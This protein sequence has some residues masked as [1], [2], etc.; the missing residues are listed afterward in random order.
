MLLALG[1][2]KMS[3]V[4]SHAFIFN[5]STQYGRLIYL[6]RRTLTGAI[7]SSSWP[8]D[9]DRTT[10]E[11]VVAEE[12]I[13]SLEE[14]GDCYRGWRMPSLIQRDRIIRN[15]YCPYVCNV[16]ESNV[17]CGLDIHFALPKY[18]CKRNTRGRNSED[19]GMQAFYAC[20]SW[21]NAMPWYV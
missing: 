4:V 14:K 10:E 18:L 11:R 12:Y 1:P 2:A 3:D 16:S 8:R 7:Y 20:W 19:W 15:K 21:G 17:K 13:M 6:R 5:L 9:L